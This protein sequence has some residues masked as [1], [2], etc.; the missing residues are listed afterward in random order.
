M[1]ETLLSVITLEVAFA[2]QTTVLWRS[3]FNPKLILK[4]TSL[5]LV[6]PVTGIASRICLSHDSLFSSDKSVKLHTLIVFQ[7]VSEV[8]CSRDAKGVDLYK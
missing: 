1:C 5:F 2:I 4:M 3:Q 8:D 7:N 6:I